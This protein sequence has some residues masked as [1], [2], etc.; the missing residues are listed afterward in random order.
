MLIG[1]QSWYP[2]MLTLYVQLK[3]MQFEALQQMQQQQMQKQMLTQTL[4]MQQ[5]VSA[6]LR[7]PLV[8]F[9]ILSTSCQ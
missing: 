9:I 1:L 7:T 5:Q 3:Q 6:L 2:C 8:S 4:L